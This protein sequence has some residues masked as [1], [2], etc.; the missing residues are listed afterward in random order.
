MRYE[1]EAAQR[2]ARKVQYQV[3]YSWGDADE[4]MSAEANDSAEEDIPALEADRTHHILSIT[5]VTGTNYKIGS[6]LKIRLK[7]IACTGTE[8]AE[9]P[10]VEMVGVHYQ[11][12]TLGSRTQT[13]K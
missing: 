7:R 8:P 9:D 12:N 10:F 3:F 6:L 1:Y 2:T 4:V 5:T 11:I 13:V